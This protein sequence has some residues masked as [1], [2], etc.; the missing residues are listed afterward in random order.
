MI[1]A[2]DECPECGDNPPCIHYCLVCDEFEPEGT[3]VNGHCWKHCT[4]FC[5]EEE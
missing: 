4:A 5:E 1:S 2:F 3:C